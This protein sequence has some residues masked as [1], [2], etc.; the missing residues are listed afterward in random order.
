MD[1][2]HAEDDSDGVIVENNWVDHFPPLYRAIVGPPGTV[3]EQGD[4]HASIL[5][6]LAEGADVNACTDEGWTP[7]MVSASTGQPYLTLLLLRCGADLDAVDRHGNDAFAWSEHR[8][9]GYDD[10]IVLTMETNSDH[11]CCTELLRAARRPWSPATHHLFPS[12]LRNRAVELMMI[13]RALSKR[14]M[15]D[16]ADVV[17][18]ACC[19]STATEDHLA[20]GRALVDVWEALIMPF[21]ILRTPS[22]ALFATSECAVRDVSPADHAAPEQPP[23]S[24]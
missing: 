5:A 8:V 9:R 19:S 3:G 1:L 20:Y 7:L 16:G 12:A 17:V 23:P 15:T 21:V 2:A 10:D 11:R 4:N 14:R 24:G 13:G 22:A 18:S 6:L